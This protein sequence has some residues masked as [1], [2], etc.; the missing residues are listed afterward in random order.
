MK[1]SLRI[2]VAD[3]EPVVQRFFREVLP[4]MGHEVVAVA[5]TGRELV[6][7]CHT[8]NPNLIITD[9]KMPEMDGITAACEIY[10]KHTVP[11][12]LV[13]AHHDPELIDRAESDH[14]MAYLIKPIKQADLEVAIQ[15]A[16]WRFEQFQIL[17]AEAKNLRQALQHRKLIERAKGIIMKRGGLDEDEAFRRLQKLA[18]DKNLRVIDVAEIVLGTETESSPAGKG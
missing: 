9:I 13:S 1:R 12:I 7:R 18:R 10:R 4:R 2:A 3:D 14:V 17:Q 15:L 6:E 5:G 8:S 11:V 16:S